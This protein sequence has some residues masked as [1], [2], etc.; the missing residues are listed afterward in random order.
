MAKRVISYFETPFR[1]LEFSPEGRKLFTAFQASFNTQAALLRDSDCS[2]RCGTAAWQLAV[3]SASMLVLDIG[4]GECPPGVEL[5]V[6]SHHVCRAFS[7]LK[8]FHDVV[9]FW[10][11]K[12]PAMSDHVRGDTSDT[13]RQMSSSERLNVVCDAALP[14]SQ[15]QEFQPTQPEIPEVAAS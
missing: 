2:A 5:Q 8:L 11:E 4:L 6:Q 10:T 12:V 1:V 7:Q 14:H 3:L 13:A 15:F 9:D